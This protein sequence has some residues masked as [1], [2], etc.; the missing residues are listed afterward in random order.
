MH[1]GG[2]FRRKRGIYHAVP[3]DAALSP[4]GLRHNINAVVGFPSGSMTG[5]ALVL[6][7]FV[8]HAQ[9]FWRE[10]LGQLSRD[11]IFRLHDP[12]RKRQL[13]HCQDLKQAAAIPHNDRL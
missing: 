9:T 5:M 3:V 13:A 10:S 1:A 6:V 4:E 7:G 2:K 8:N 11:D 12:G